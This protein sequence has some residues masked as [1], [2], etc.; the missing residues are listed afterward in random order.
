MKNQVQV[1]ADI[2]VIILTIGIIPNAQAH[3]ITNLVMK[4][5][6]QQQSAMQL[7]GGIIPVNVTIDITGAIHSVNNKKL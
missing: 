1:N 7:H 2:N 4:L 6:I 3:V 5:P